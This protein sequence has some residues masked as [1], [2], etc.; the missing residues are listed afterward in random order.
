MANTKFLTAIIAVILLSSPLFGKDRNP[1]NYPQKAKVLSFSQRKGKT[2]LDCIDNSIGTDCDIRSR[3]Y[4][5]LELEIDGQ[6]YTV[7]CWRCDPL[8]PSQTY[9][10]KVELKD[11]KILII[12]QKDRRRG[13]TPCTTR[14]TL[15]LSNL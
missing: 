10:A 14:Q 3:T 11:M 4:H 12:H 15:Y 8:I 13:F 1:E 6:R 5:I 9:P 7:S 2:A